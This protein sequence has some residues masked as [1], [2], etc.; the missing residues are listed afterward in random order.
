MSNK[1]E[2]KRIAWDCF[3]EIPSYSRWDEHSDLLEAEIEQA[4]DAAEHKA[5]LNLLRAIPKRLPKHAHSD[6]M[7]A[8]DTGCDVCEIGVLI[9]EHM[10][11]WEK[12][13]AEGKS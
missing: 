13:N 6:P 1:E 9:A 10:R 11:E 8:P 7:D 4:L 5:L 3:S 12:K 2:S